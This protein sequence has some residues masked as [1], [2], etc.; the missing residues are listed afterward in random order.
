LR[1]IRK[2]LV[3]LLIA[4]ASLP[5]TTVASAQA[6]DDA[7]P[8]TG[9]IIVTGT[10]LDRSLFET[11]QSVDVTTAEE[12]EERGITQ[13][14]EL[15]V[16]SANVS[17]NDIRGLTIRG[18]TTTFQV[19]F[20]FRPNIAFIRDGVETNVQSFVELQS[21]WD[22]GQVEIL[23]GSQTTAYGRNAIG[24]AV[25]INTREPTEE[26]E[27]AFRV[28]LGSFDY[29]VASGVVSG[30]LI[31]D[32]LLGR[33]SVDWQ[34]IDTQHPNFYFGD[35]PLESLVMRGKLH[36]RPAGWEAL[37]ARLTV[38]HTR[39]TLFDFYQEFEPLQ[40][41]QAG[42]LPRE[43][44]DY[45]PFR[46]SRPRRNT[47]IGL[48]ATIALSDRL[49]LQN[50]TSYSR[51]FSR[52]TTLDDSGR[53]IEN[54]CFETFV[55]PFTPASE[56]SD[57]DEAGTTSIFSQEM[58]LTRSTSA[59][60]LMVG[61][62]YQ[63]Q[64]IAEE[65][66]FADNP[67]GTVTANETNRFGLNV[68]SAFGQASWRFRPQFELTAAGRWTREEASN[69]GADLLTGGITAPIRVTSTRFTPEVSLRYTINDDLNVAITG[70]RGF[71]AAGV[72]RQFSL[73]QA[74]IA[75]EADA[76]TTLTL[77]PLVGRDGVIQFGSEIAD[78][79]ELSVRWR[80]TRSFSLNTNAFYTR[81]KDR[82]E[83][84][85]AIATNPT[86]GEEILLIDQ[87]F[88]GTIDVV[89]NIGKSEIYGIELESEWQPMDK[90]SLYATFGFQRGRYLDFPQSDGTNLAGERLVDFPEVTANAGFNY[91]GPEGFSFGASANYASAS[92]RFDDPFILNPAPART[93]F[94]G[95][96]AYGWR[97]FQLSLTGTNLLNKRYL[98]EAEFVD[99]L[100][101]F[102]GS[103]RQV[104]LQLQARF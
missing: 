104:R 96:I 51:R 91:G 16:R 2:M 68:Y 94:D 46:E 90:L 25:V 29:R 84:T 10:K 42:E 97:Q 62:F 50:L 63:R 59:L 14:N 4:A 30:P 72:Q 41:S 52:T 11:P 34:R 15:L 44:F 74:L 12:A 28:G 17:V 37:D 78:T 77:P 101:R 9:D 3:R 95:R 35:L 100:I 22:L 79:A 85:T 27:A 5:V 24:G 66:Q 23:R 54:L 38:E 89:R 71:R 40:P 53:P 83:F 73:E 88:G 21:L 33:F 6:A 99:P 81:F 18:S 98:V 1:M 93:I 55:A 39:G 32:Q 60:D 61:G 82:Q 65:F 70:R 43:A 19:D 64:V 31:G 48:D 87:Q 57:F 103:E 56:C 102:R 36:L 80:P 86:T 26:P 69:R 7:A 92:Q 8:N 49:S 13:V 20:V 67:S 47:I 45:T 75:A 58:R 76:G